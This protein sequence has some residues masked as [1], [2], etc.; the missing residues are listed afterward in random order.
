M[1]D[2]Q[3]ETLLR[4]VR[5]ERFES[6]PVGL[7]VDGPWIS[8]WRGVP[9]LDYYGSDRIWLDTN[10]AVVEAFPDVLLLA[11][12]WS[13]YG[14]SGNPSAFGCRCIW[15]E[16]G[17]PTVAKLLERLRFHRPTAETELPN[18]RPPSV[19]SQTSAPCPRGDGEQGPSDTIRHD[20]RA[21]HDR[22]LPAGGIRNS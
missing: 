7:L 8:Y 19:P 20:S 11:G 13:E 3:W 4:L 14:M 5:G 17:F 15:P 22:L 18:R 16:N 10:L 9:L 21:D 12:F 1:T 6:P 2:T